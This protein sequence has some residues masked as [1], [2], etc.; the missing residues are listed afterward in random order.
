M[1][2]DPTSTSDGVQ[3]T[4]LLQAMLGSSLDQLGVGGFELQ[5]RLSSGHVVQLEQPVE[6][7]DAV[8]VVAHSLEGLALLVPLLNAEVEAV[9]ADDAGGLLLTLGGTT[10]RCP[11]GV[12]FEAWNVSGPGGVL[13]V[14]TPGGGLAT[15]TD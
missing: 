2:T 15:W 11:G 7:G 8:G 5:L 13:V 3:A 10:L 4:L 14:S 1:T 9:T 12:E 6:V